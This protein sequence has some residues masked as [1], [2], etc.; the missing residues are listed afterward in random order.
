MTTLGERIKERREKLNL[1]QDQLA[2]MMGITRHVL[3]SYE[4]D[5]N[6]PPG[7]TLGS[8]ADALKTSADYLLG[9]TDDPTPP[10]NRNE[11]PTE[12]ELKIR[13][14]LIEMEDILRKSDNV[15]ETMLQHTLRIMEVTFLE[16][17]GDSKRKKQ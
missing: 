4:S 10:V 1:K 3:S 12:D 11:T 13:R 6:F 8:L 14:A 17:L 2:D 16:K 5:R 15:D 7:K 9:R